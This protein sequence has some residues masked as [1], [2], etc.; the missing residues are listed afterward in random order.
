[1]RR[2]WN[3]LTLAAV[4]LLG[5]ACDV[6]IATEIIIQSDYSGQLVVSIALDEETANDLIAAG[7]VPD[8]GLADALAGQP[9]WDVAS[10]EGVPAGARV[11]HDFAHVSEVGSLLAELSDPLGPEDGALWEG[12]DLRVDENGN[13]VLDGRAGLVPPSVVG[14]VGDG[15]TFDG[16]DLAR[17]LDQQGREAVHHDLRV[18]SSGR[19]GEN[20]AD[21]RIDHALIWELPVGGM[22]S[23]HAVL[24]VSAS[25]DLARLLAVAVLAAAATAVITILTRRRPRGEP[26]TA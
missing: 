3:A 16:E 2:Y 6:R 13:V 7:F 5:S 23:V 21:V 10:I 17:L 1:M 9:G 20:D 25:P 4:V 26:P 19:P 22:R 8:T 14:A 11:T 24:P 15:V 18:T 12:L